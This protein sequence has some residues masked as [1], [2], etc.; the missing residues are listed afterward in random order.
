VLAY[1][2]KIRRAVEAEN[3]KVQEV[4]A[5]EIANMNK[6]YHFKDY[7]EKVQET[8]I[9]QSLIISCNM[10]QSS[11]AND[12]TSS[13]VDMQKTPLISP[14][15]F[16]QS[17]PINTK[18]SCTDVNKSSYVSKGRE[19]SEPQSAVTLELENFFGQLSNKNFYLTLESLPSKFVHLDEQRSFCFEIINLVD[20]YEF[21]IGLVESK[22][23]FLSL[24][25]EI[26]K[27]YSTNKAK[28]VA[29]VAQ[30]KFSYN[31]VSTGKLCIVNVEDKFY[32]AL[33]RFAIPIRVDCKRSIDELVTVLCF[34]Y[35]FHV[36]VPVCMLYPIFE[37]FCAVAPRCIP[38]R[39]DKIVPLD[40]LT[41]DDNEVWSR[42]AIDTFAKIL[43]KWPVFRGT[44]CVKRKREPEVRLP[45][46]EKDSLKQRE[47]DA[48][49]QAELETERSF[50]VEC[51]EPLSVVIQ[52]G[53]D[54]EKKEKELGIADAMVGACLAK[55]STFSRGQAMRE[56]EAAGGEED[57]YDQ[58]M[59]ASQVNCMMFE[60]DDAPTSGLGLNEE[61]PDEHLKFKN[62]RINKYIDDYSTP[63]SLNSNSNLSTE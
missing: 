9:D 35:G 30:P 47:L 2:V 58:I 4:F 51:I 17:E 26:N 42:R 49:K 12:M 57:E 18:S 5:H 1:M 61:S 48:L 28:L 6:K 29:F 63:S 54:S 23:N 11:V 41:S 15:I 56:V 55:Y 21:Y 37:D 10:N 8:Q 50:R 31:F 43:E 16:E 52:Y 60:D 59:S 40:T 39:F 19:R 7:D 44:V 27:W 45:M 22:K 25:A 38:A 20:P 62:Q 14:S 32:R 53:V 34:D 46:N 36:T 13:S 3:S 33:I 24:E